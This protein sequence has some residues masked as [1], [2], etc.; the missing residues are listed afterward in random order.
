VLTVTYDGAILRT[1][2]APGAAAPAVYEVH[3][4]LLGAGIVSRISSG[5]NRGETLHHQFV[6]LAL[7]HG[8][9]G[10]DLTL[11]VPVV[12]GVPRHALAVWITRRGALEPVQAAGGWWE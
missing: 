1:E 12:A 5:E 4:V 10:R 11:A 7:V 3:A 2:F 9:L 8:A 6:A